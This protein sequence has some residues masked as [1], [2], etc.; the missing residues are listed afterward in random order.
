M[1]KL[2]MEPGVFPLEA[3]GE[4]LLQGEHGRHLAKSLR[5]AR[6]EET[7]LCNGQGMDYFCTVTEVQG[8]SVT[9]RIDRMARSESESPL[10][11]TLYQ[12]IPKGDKM[13]TIV[14][15]AVEMGV[16]RVVPVLTSRC[17]SR[18]DAKAMGK[19]VERWNTIA[20]Q[21]AQQSGRGIVPQVLPMCTLQQAAE[22]GKGQ[23]GCVLYEDAVVS[24]KTFV[25]SL[26]RSCFF[27]VGP[28]GGFSAEEI[29]LLAAHGVGAFSLGRRILRC[30]TAGA[31]FLA[32]LTY[33]KEL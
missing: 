7:I 27:I 31:A 29:A 10:E 8:E 28:E 1:P 19:K 18:P 12:A 33:E 9:V 23:Q 16:A 5:I 25:R 30:E 4:L 2:F 3:G 6:G 13:D 21:A 26:S 24:A 20:R 22:A 15:K 11:I 14:Q 32:I 17:V